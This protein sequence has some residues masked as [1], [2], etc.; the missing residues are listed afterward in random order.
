VFSLAGKSAVELFVNPS[1]LDFMG[2][3]FIGTN[4]TGTFN[5]TPIQ[6]GE[7]VSLGVLLA[8]TVYSIKLDG[9]VTG[10]LGGGYDGVLK[11]AAV[12]VPAAVW[13]FGSALLGLTVFSR[14]RNQ[15]ANYA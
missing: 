10:S 3:K 7:F 5:L 1:E 15:L 13:L 9:L 4:L 2:S 12:P 14:R 6:M 8:N 11:V